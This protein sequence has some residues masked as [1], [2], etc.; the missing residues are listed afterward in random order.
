[1][2]LATMPPIQGQEGVMEM[3][4]S[5]WLPVGEVLNV[6]AMNYPNKEAVADKDKRYTFREW[7]ERSN[8]L[9]NALK[10]QGI[11]H[12]DRFAILARNCV[13]WMEIYAAAA[14]GGQVA[15]PIMFRLAPP[16]IEYIVKH[17][18]CRALIVAEEF[19]ESVETMKRRLPIP[20]EN[21]IYLGDRKMPPGYFG[22]ETL[23]TEG[24]S[25]KPSA[26]VDGEDVWTFMY[27]SGTT[28]R[29]KGVV[30]THESYIAQ[31]VLNDINIGVRPEDR[32]MLVMPMCHV[33]SIFYSFA[34]AYVGASCFVYNMVSF[35]P[36][37]L[38]RTIDQEK[39]TFTSLV[40]THY[41]MMLS[42]PDHVKNRYDVSSIRQLL[43][44]SA[45]ARKDTKL[46]IMKYFRNA[47]LW[48]AYGS[49]EA[50]LVTL[51][52]PEEQMKKLGSI[53]KEI[54]GT[55]RIKILDENRRPV[56]PGEIGEL[57]SRT[58]MIFKEYWKDPEKTKSVFEGEWFSAGDMVRSDE[59]GYYYLVDRKANM[60][61]TG[62]E[63]VYP[64]EVESIL[65][66]HPAVKDVAVIGVP[67]KKWGEAVKAVVIPHDT[68][69]PSEELARELIQWCRGKIA[70][71]K[72][73]K[74]V[75]FIRDAEMPR[76]GT[77]K[78]LH[79]V[80]RE[81]YGSWVEG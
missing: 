25:K 65:G 75:D 41:I 63:N 15:V 80:L 47:E 78:I 31:Y 51:L 26:V 38:L 68:Y 28:G 2:A 79:R 37:D 12:G 1:M 69:T 60:V 11:G 50:G 20:E 44:S 32:V 46:D 49:T 3:T 7:D 9:A 30:R 57:F 67:D 14:K 81:R 13:E 29:P 16:E 27:T 73:P 18:D 54:F 43:I 34:Y 52:R 59:D 55:D 5:K 4:I 72:I 22:Y 71:Y 58:P 24:S 10:N 70:G 21:Y 48:E 56:P 77:G 23:M 61:I 42:L 35:D 39:I 19:V 40:P 64:S 33:N 17:A 74:S 62:G 8:R 45:P 6:L 36:E 66:P 76:T 53:G